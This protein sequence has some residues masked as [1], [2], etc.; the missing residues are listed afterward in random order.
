VLFNSPFFIFVFLPITLIGF[1]LLGARGLRRLAI[2][3]LV[4][5]SL[6]FYGWFKPEYLMLLAV[7]IVFN[8]F[9]GIKLSRDHHEGRSTPIA[10]AVGLAVNLAVLAYYKYTNFFIDNANVVFGTHFVLQTIILPLGISFFTFQKIAYL[11]D[12]YR[13]EAEEYNFLDFSLFVMYFPQLI[14]GPIVHHKEM[15]P[16][17]RKASIFKLCPDD[18][19]AGLTLFTIGVI[20]KVLIADTVTGWSDP[21][22]A[23]AHSGAAPTLIDAW[24]GALSFAFQIYFDFSG[25]TDMALGLAL[26]IGIRL[27]LNFNSPYQATNITDFWRRW[28]MTL[29]RFLRDYLYIPLGGNRHGPRRRYVNLLA[30]MLIGGLWHGAAWTFVAWGGL[31]GFYLVVNHGWHALRRRLGWTPRGGAG[32]RWAGRLLTF[33]VV[34]MAWVFFR[35]ESFHAAK[36]MLKGMAGLNGVAL[37]TSYSA[38]LGRVAS[39]LQHVGVKFDDALV[40]HGRGVLQGI[41]LLGL[42]AVVWL[43]PNSQEL[44]ARFR[45]ALQLIAPARL[46]AFVGLGAA[47]LGLVGSDG[48][49][50]LSATTGTVVGTVLLVS[51][52]Y[53]ALRGT[54]LQPFI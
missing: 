44:L 8:Y 9:Y 45:P 33:G 16:Q 47:R 29:S 21:I 22:F 10:L 35:A 1:F 12:A 20:K 4:L 39:L 2:A 28:H 5:A 42:L 54:T 14:A 25:Y 49:F 52:L 40:P 46:K 7:L 53:Q 43:L 23:A 41:E 3:W 36:L 26:M 15:I 37:P 50:A 51:L 13:G 6:V 38:Y 31:H 11:V 24:C 17:F 34:V 32:G 19:A 30:T 48:S 27:P 18:L